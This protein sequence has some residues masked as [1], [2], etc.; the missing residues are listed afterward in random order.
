[1]TLSIFAGFFLAD[2]AVI[3]GIFE[4]EKVASVSKRWAKF[5]DLLFYFQLSFPEV[6]KEA[7]KKKGER[8]EREREK[9]PETQIS[10]YTILNET[11]TEGFL[12]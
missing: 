11:S 3:T 4:K 6:C 12:V 8:M 9:T 5:Q 10:E 2:A 7:K 1:V